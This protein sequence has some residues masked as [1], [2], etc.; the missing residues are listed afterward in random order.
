M[1]T[2]EVFAGNI[3]NF[4]W[5]AST[6]LKAFEI[7]DTLQFNASA[8]ANYKNQ[9]L[10]AMLRL[11]D[12]ARV[13]YGCYFGSVVSSLNLSQTQHPKVFAVDVSN[14]LPLTSTPR[15]VYYE[16][17]NQTLSLSSN[18]DNANTEGTTSDLELVQNVL[19][20]IVIAPQM[21]S[22]IV[23]RQGANVYKMDKNFGVTVVPLIRF[24]ADPIEQ[25]TTVTFV[26]VENDV[27]LTLPRP[28]LGNAKRFDFTR[29]NR[30]SRGGDLILY[31]DE[32]WP[33]TKTLILSFTW[34]PEQQITDILLFLKAT[35]GRS[36]VYNDHYGKVWNGF[37]MTPATQIVFESRNN[38]SITIEFQGVEQE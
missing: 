32:I 2:I 21:E 4:G 11:S 36:I 10:N 17:V 26:D 8:V 33:R 30:R 23:W 13:T 35:L 6:N 25:V 31:R 28:E 24:F 38:R 3:L 7:V 37:I 19:E 1:A 5:L 34:L 14:Y 15:K 18:E 16:I 20:N 9:N 22:T 12:T 27:T 29:I